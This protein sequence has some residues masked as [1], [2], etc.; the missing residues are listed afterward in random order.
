MEKFRAFADKS[1]S[2]S[3]LESSA[4]F[5]SFVFLICVLF[6]FHVKEYSLAFFDHE[7]LIAT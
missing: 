1:T 7:E 2:N 6:S 3:L 5:R 4:I